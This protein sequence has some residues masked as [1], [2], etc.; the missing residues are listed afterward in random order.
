VRCRGR[1]KGRQAHMR[2]NEEDTLELG[3]DRLL[4]DIACIV[5]L[6]KVRIV[7]II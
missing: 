2:Y 7:V 6:L 4:R 3:R 5:Y 1:K